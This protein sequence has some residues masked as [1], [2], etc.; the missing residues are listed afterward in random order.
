MDGRGIAGFARFSFVNYARLAEAHQRLTVAQWVELA[1]AAGLRGVQSET[2]ARGMI[3]FV[4]GVADG[5][6]SA[7]D[8]SRSST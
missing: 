7:D 1:E 2:R 8:V 3:A 6:G 5:S 4:K